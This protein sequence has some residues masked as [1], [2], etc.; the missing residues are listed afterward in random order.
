MIAMPAAELLLQMIGLELYFLFSASMRSN[1][2][3]G[4][5]YAGCAAWPSHFRSSSQSSPH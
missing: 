4:S 2:Q 3:A 1:S 5:V